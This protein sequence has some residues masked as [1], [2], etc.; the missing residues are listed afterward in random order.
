M[1]SRVMHIMSSACSSKHR[2]ALQEIF[3]LS[4]HLLEYGSLHQALHLH[5]QHIEAGT[6]RTGS[7]SGRT[8]AQS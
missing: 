1:G 2:G 8:V 3:P 7:T 5:V 4:I 6:F